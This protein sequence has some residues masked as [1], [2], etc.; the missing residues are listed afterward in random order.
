MTN[1]TTFS[2]S[3]SFRVHTGRGVRKRTPIWQDQTPEETFA[4]TEEYLSNQKENPYPSPLS[5]L[6]T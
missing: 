2:F 5:S 6:L 4:A 3:S 1:F